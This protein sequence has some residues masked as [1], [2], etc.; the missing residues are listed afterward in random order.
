MVLVNYAAQVAYAADLYGLRVNPAGV[1]LLGATLAWFLVA[2]ATLVEGRRLGYVLLLLYVAA[3]VAF[4]VHGQIV[5]AFVGYGFLYALTHAHDPVVW[6]VFVI[7]DLNL[8]AA[9]IALVYLLGPGR[10]LARG[11]GQRRLRS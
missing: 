11:T 3:Q 1:V 10:D 9:V 7:G 6:V 4:Y 8:L 2:F 5:L